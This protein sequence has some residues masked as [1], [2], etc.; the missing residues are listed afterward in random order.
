MQSNKNIFE[1]YQSSGIY[2]RV[3]FRKN[4]ESKLDKLNKLKLKILNLKEIY[5]K[6]DDQIVF[7]DGD[8]HSNVMIVGDAPGVV[9]EINCKPFSGEIGKLLNKMLAAI[10]L[11]R[12][13]V[14]LTNIINFRLS[15]NKMPSKIDILRFKPLIEEH[16]D[17]INPQIIFLLGF[18]TLKVFFE[19]K[20]SII[21]ARGKWFKLEI[22]GKQIDCIMSF[23]PQ[24][25]SKQPQQKKLS[26][27][28]LKK[29]K[30]K[31]NERNL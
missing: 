6:K 24:F 19:N 10:N 4:N 15:D 22:K 2:D 3:I 12:S 26:W 9:D 5:N 31:I 28:D 30:A 14:Y 25:L 18:V 1:F 29:L 8:T 17:I 11:D 16:I 21:E 13:K 27:E 20:I 23:H 7:F